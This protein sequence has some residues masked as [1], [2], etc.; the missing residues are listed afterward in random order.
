MAAAVGRSLK[1]MIIFLALAVWPHIIGTFTFRRQQSA[2]CSIQPAA[3]TN[4]INQD[5]KQEL[6]RP[7]TVC[8][9]A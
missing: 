7:A 4:W 2:A 5:D 8:A 6:G 1:K 9:S 3:R